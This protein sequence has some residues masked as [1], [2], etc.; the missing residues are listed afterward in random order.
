MKVVRGKRG[1]K[2]RK[3]RKGGRRKDAGEEEP[4]EE[5]NVGGDPTPISVSR[6]I[7]E[8]KAGR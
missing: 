5:A 7:A 3:R 2:K 4:A 1:G 8:R 6:E